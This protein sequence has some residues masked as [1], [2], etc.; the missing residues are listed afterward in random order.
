MLGARYAVLGFADV[1]GGLGLGVDD[2]SWLSTAY[3]AGDVAAW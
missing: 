1:R 3:A 2:G